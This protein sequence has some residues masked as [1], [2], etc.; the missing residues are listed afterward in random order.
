[1]TGFVHQFDRQIAGGG[2]DV[3]GYIDARTGHDSN[4]NAFDSPFNSL[5]ATTS[6]SFCT[7]TCSAFV[8]GF[9]AGAN[10]SHLGLAYAN[11]NNSNP[12]TFIDGAAALGPVAGESSSAGPATTLALA[13]T[14]EPARDRCKVDADAGASDVQF[15]PEK[16][17]QLEAN[18]ASQDRSR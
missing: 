11:R 17:L 12:Q 18:C 8:D 9:L 6:S 16:Q 4:I 15:S 14:P 1:L 7:P 10:A 13:A 2:S 5:T 3:S